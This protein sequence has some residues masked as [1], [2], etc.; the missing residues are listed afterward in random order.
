MRVSLQQ[1]AQEVE[2]LTASPIAMTK[3]I[4]Y[5]PGRKAYN[6]KT[7]TDLKRSDIPEVISITIK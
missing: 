6:M 1:L 7:L 4:D 2:S 3:T 5:S